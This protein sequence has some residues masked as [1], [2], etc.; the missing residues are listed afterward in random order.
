MVSMWRHILSYTYNNVYV[1][2]SGDTYGIEFT[3]DISLNDWLEDVYDEVDI[4]INN[5]YL[6][7]AIPEVSI[8]VDIKIKG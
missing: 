7:L 4:V 8:H 5:R 3:R 6:H 2:F 1:T